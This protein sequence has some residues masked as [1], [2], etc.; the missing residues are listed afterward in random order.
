MEARGS[1]RGVAGDDRVE[2]RPTFEEFFAAQWERLFR[3]L[4]LLTGSSQQAEDLTQ[5]AFLKLY[6]RWD[7]LGH[8]ENLEGYVFRVALNAHRSLYR[9][10]L[11]AAKR[12]LPV[13]KAEEDPFERVSEQDRAVRFLL[14]L[15]ER[16]RAAIVLTGI[17]GFG[18]VDAAAALGVKESTV[19][20][21]VA[22]AR[23]RLSEM[24][25][26]DA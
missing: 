17:H 26:D 6:E 3:A 22:Q 10:S 7:R 2:G 12:A 11:L 18:Y 24:E 14:R 13:G 1:L 15:S 16:Q 19:R 4:V 8:V 21:L 9:R 20:S 23:S 25:Y 5:D